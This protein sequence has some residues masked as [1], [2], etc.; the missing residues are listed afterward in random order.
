VSRV[1][2]VAPNTPSQLAYSCRA[3]ETIVFAVTIR[4]LRLRGCFKNPLT[5]DEI[6]EQFSPRRSIEGTPTPLGA[7]IVA[8]SSDLTRRIEIGKGHDVSSLFAP[9]RAQPLTQCRSGLRRHLRSHT[10]W[11][12]TLAYPGHE[13]FRGEDENGIPFPVLVQP[14]R[15]VALVIGDLVPL[16][17]ALEFNPDP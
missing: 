7:S 14:E 5:D 4:C 8:K 1:A 16:H 3:D 12:A 2:R 9:P 13:L 11:D 17:V 10:L 6:R 15:Q